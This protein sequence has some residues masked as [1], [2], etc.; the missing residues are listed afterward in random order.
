MCSERGA[1]D[2]ALLPRKHATDWRLRLAFTEV[3]IDAEC[4]KIPNQYFTGTWRE[5]EQKRSAS[6]VIQKISLEPILPLR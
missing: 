4:R 1:K 2:C 6:T 5:P 3:S